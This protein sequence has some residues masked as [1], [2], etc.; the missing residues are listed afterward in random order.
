MLASL[1][2]LEAECGRADLENIQQSGNS[3][4]RGSSSTVIKVEIGSCP[5]TF[6]PPATQESMRKEQIFLRSKGPGTC[7][8]G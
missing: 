8:D 5:G 1:L 3:H 7:L 4:A 6:E 2:G